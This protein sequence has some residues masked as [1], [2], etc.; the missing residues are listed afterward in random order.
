MNNPFKLTL[1]ALLVVNAFPAYAEDT[2]Q[3]EVNLET[4]E[5]KGKRPTSKLGE[6][7]TRRNQLDENLV[8]DVRDL[9]RYDPAVSVVEG[10]RGSTNGFVIRGVDKDR[11]AINVDGLT[12][13]ES[14]SS[15]G[16]QEL[17]GAYGNFNANRNAAELENISEVSIRKGAD[18][19]TSGS[20]ALGGAVE[21]KTKSPADVVNE[22]KPL[23][24]GL[25]GGYTG[26][27]SE[28]VG[29]TDLAAYFKGFD[30]RFVYTRRHGHELKNHGGGSDYTQHNKS[31]GVYNP[32]SNN[33]SYFGSFGKF[34]AKPD[35]QY[36]VSK[37]TLFKAGYH[38]NPYNYLSGVYEDYR[39]DRKT[40]EL[41][42]LWAADYQGNVSYEMRKRNDITYQKRSG[43]EYENQLASGPWDK[44]T[45]NYDKQKIQMSTMTWDVPND[46]ARSGTNS[47]LYFVFRRRTQDLKQFRAKADKSFDFGNNSWSMTY[48]AGIGNEKNSNDN[49]TVFVRAFRPELETSRRTTDT[50]LLDARSKKHHIFWN[51]S[52]NLNG[53]Y[54]F[55]AG[56][57][58]DWIRN[59]ILPNNQFIN[60]MKQK[61]LDEAKAKFGAPSYALHFDWKFAP[62]WTFL[63]KYSTG[64]RAPTTN[65]M[66]FTFPHP[67]MTVLANKD[68]KEEKAHNYEL[69]ISN[70]GKW[71]NVLLSGFH[72]R[73]KDFIDFAYLGLRNTEF[74]NV[75]EQKWQPR[76][77]TAPT[78]QNV[79]RDSATVNGIELSGNWKLNSIG[80]P[81]GMF[82]SWTASYIKGKAKQEDGS[83]TPI[84][85][86]A[87]F[88]AVFGI[89]YVQPEDR[90]SLK[91]NLS[92]TARKKPKDTVHSN[93]DLKNP[94]PYAK[95]SNNY[96]LVDLV[97]HY[98]FGKHVTLRGGV[99]NLFNKRYYT[100]DS[101]RSIREFGT[102]NRVDN[103]NGSDGTPQHASCAHQGIQRFTAP[104]RSYGLTLEAK[105]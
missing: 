4:V 34:R 17:F 56:I 57:R 100:W 10:G 8:Q 103:C 24:V 32:L 72:T 101:L 78:W 92:Y 49:Y 43:I 102:V 37:S 14:L 61:G 62:G 91:T 85:A 60:A 96:L 86:L 46:L 40:D 27:N 68:L 83:K 53:K 70:Q 51:N 94:W 89:G 26:R 74:W 95:H 6:T 59:N 66:W 81:E 80:L 50:L 77:Y 42:N 76:P 21:Y 38:F 15:E 47:D 82:A 99:F 73:Y 52:F 2:S 12:Q 54:R 3:Q 25:K 44:L 41:S 84:N 1:M 39:L 33:R 90:W 11:V 16:F 64:F 35:P 19:I 30:T 75:N 48:G 31:D 67:D 13:A 65:E 88:G 18:S 71:G 20:G 58:Y 23:Y 98:R 93:D 7:K 97:G 5:V 28:Y 45:L 29:S 104:K 22:E 69:G 63:S 87:P 9:V 36:Y 105:F 55:G 79:N